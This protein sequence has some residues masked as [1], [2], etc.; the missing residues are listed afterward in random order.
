MEE[1]QFAY[2]DDDATPGGSAGLEVGAAEP[3]AEHPTTTG[4]IAIYCTA[5]SYDTKGLREHLVAG[6]YACEEHPEVMHSRYVRRD[7]QATGDCLFFEYGVAVFWDLSPRQEQSLLQVRARAGLGREDGL[8]AERG[9]GAEGRPRLWRLPR[10]DLRASRRTLR[11][12]NL[13]VLRQFEEGPL[14]LARVE[15]D[16]FAF[17]YLQYSKP[18]IQVG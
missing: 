8:P 10:G 14:T 13:Q 6:G 1:G 15:S 7:G 5:S 4:R 18:F 11:S 16:T 2:E 3:A 9:D 12:L 17:K